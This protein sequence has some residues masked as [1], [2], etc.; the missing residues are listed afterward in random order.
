MT[1]DIEHWLTPMLDALLM[2]KRGDEAFARFMEAAISS[3]S[4]GRRRAL[5]PTDLA[6][7]AALAEMFGSSRDRHIGTVDWI[8]LGQLIRD[9]LSW[10]DYPAEPPAPT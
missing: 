9:E 8:R 10:N 7:T 4:D 2:D 5:S 6:S 3:A 1:P